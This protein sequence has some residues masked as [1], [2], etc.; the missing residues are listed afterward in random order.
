LSNKDETVANLRR[1]EWAVIAAGLAAF[2]SLAVF[3]LGLPGLHYDEAKEAGLPAMQLLRSL[4]ID[5]FR[6]AG[7]R[8]GSTLFPL[9][10]VD[11]IGATNVALAVPF[12]A[13]GGNNVVTLRLLPVLLSAFGLVLLYLLAREWYNRRVAVIAFLLLA[14]NPSFVFWSRQGIFVT[15]TIIPLSLGAVLCLARWQRGGGRGY[16]WS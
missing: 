1:W 3:Q 5:A 2:L 6:G 8:L 16:L 9:M 4:P 7:I 15:S 13:I 10:V 11:Y 14:V 12:L